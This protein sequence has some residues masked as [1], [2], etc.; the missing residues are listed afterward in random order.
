MSLE[1]LLPT[2]MRGSAKFSYLVD[3][4]PLNGNAAFRADSL[5]DGN[6]H[7]RPIASAYPS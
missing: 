5:A 7:P 2:T 1:L 6:E 3:Y 4:K